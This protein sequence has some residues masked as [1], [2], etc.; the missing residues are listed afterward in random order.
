[1]TGRPTMPVLYAIHGEKEG[2]IGELLRGDVTEEHLVPREN[3]GS[4]RR[5]QRHRT[6]SAPQKKGNERTEGMPPCVRR[7]LA[8]NSFEKQLHKQCTETHDVLPDPACCVRTTLEC[9]C[10]YVC[11]GG[12]GEEGGGR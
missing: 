8:R 5:C 2:V 3:P 11:G 6:R 12:R 10:M 4:V 7:T 9:V 1:M